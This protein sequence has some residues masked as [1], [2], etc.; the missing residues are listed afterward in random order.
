[1]N[2]DYL[3]G[4]ID[5]EA[6]FIIVFRRDKRY[7]IGIRI[8]TKFSLPQKDKWFLERIR[9]YLGDIGNIYYHKRDKLWYFEITSY[10]ELYDLTNRICD[11]LVLKREKCKR[12]NIILRMILN[13]EHLTYEGLNKIKAAWLAPETGAN[14]R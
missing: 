11:K 7:R 2:D 9:N 13:K 6:S 4:L 1:M 12:F 3:A 8:F 10:N 5:G 14:P